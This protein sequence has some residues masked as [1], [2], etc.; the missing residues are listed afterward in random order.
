MS[1]ATSIDEAEMVST[2][3]KKEKK[4]LEMTASTVSKMRL[5]MSPAKTPHGIDR[6][7]AFALRYYGHNNNEEHAYIR[8]GQYGAHD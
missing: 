6:R 1:M 2:I 7:T 8:V 5:A 4:R 3:S